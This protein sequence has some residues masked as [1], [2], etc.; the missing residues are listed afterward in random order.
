[1]LRLGSAF[2]GI[3]GFEL[4]LHWAIE[5]LETVWQIEQDKFCQKVLKKHWPNS[6]LFDDIKTINT[7]QLPDIDIL[8]AGFP[9]Q[10]LSVA[11]KQKGIHGKKTGLFWEL[12]RIIRDFKEQG[13]R[14]PIILLENVPN[15]T[16]KGLG[17]VLGALSEVGYDAEWVI[18]S[19]KE[20]GAPHLRKRWFCVA[21]PNQNSKSNRPIYEETLE[22]DFTNSNIKHVK[23]QS[24][25]TN[26]VASPRLFKCRIGKNGRENIEND[27]QKSP[28]ESPL[29]SVD[30]GIS[31]RVARL[32]AL[33]NAI[34]PQCSELIGKRLIES[35]LLKDVLNVE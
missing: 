5:N 9:C 8:C 11:G 28:I 2:S 17:T 25:H 27:W 31:N 23:K 12:W 16:N 30:D 4:G 10:D 15:I 18:I 34:V 32:R 26:P 20:M 7:K 35:G 22:R 6:Q 14:I 33:G 19:A 1:M 29:C 13:R 21:Y 3:G 24:M